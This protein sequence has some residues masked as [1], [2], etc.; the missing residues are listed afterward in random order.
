[1]LFTSNSIYY[2]YKFLFYITL[3]TSRRPS[4]SAPSYVQSQKV[5]KLHFTSEMRKNCSETFKYIL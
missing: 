2:H 1:M 5:E 4:E 3:P